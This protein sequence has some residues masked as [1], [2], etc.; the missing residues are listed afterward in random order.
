M[1]I[2]ISQLKEHYISV[3]QARYDTYVVAKDIYTAII[4][5]NSKFHKTTLTHDLIF[6][7]EDYS[8][9]DEQLE[10]FYR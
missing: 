9:S 6:T 5:E 1:Y 4:K 2:R 7:K 10:V 8:T 3:C